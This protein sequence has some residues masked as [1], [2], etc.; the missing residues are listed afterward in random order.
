MDKKWIILGFVVLGGG[1]VGSHLVLAKNK[2]SFSEDTSK[3]PFAAEQN[4]F[5]PLGELS[6]IGTHMAPSTRAYGPNRTPEQDW[7]MGGTSSV[8]ASTGRW[9]Q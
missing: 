6:R 8:T 7:L 2:T 3:T 9:A 5:Y 4:N 1:I